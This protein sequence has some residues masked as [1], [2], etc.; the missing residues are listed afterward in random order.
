MSHAGAFAL[1]ARPYGDG[2]SNFLIF[3]F[4]SAL[5]CGCGIALG[6]GCD[7]VIERMVRLY[8]SRTIRQTVVQSIDREQI[9]Q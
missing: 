1:R 6:G 7:S 4:S 2:H 5:F 9:D 8:L 3:L